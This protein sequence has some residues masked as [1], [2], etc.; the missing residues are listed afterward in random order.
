MQIPTTWNLLE[1]CECFMGSH[2]TTC[3]EVTV[4]ETFSE[5]RIEV[6]SETCWSDFTGFLAGVKIF[7]FSK[8]S[9]SSSDVETVM[10][11]QNLL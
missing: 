6:S 8:H 4:N 7:E 5:P 1:M 3:C 11:R 10:G 2:R 9:S